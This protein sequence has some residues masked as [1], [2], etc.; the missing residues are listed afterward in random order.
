MK[1]ALPFLTALLLVPLAAS[2]SHA[3]GAPTKNTNFILLE[4][5]QFADLGGWDTDQH[6]W[7]K[8]VQPTCSR[9]DLVYR[10][11]GGDLRGAGTQRGS[12][13]GEG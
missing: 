2:S 12:G 3:A 5:E 10:S 1:Y 4:A 8:W 7:I 6:P 13:D 9:T 11:G